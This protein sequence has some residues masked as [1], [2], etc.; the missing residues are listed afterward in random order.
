[1]PSVLFEGSYL[2]NAIEEQRLGS[3]EGRQILADA[4]ANA[5]QAYREGR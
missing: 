4:I 2:S 5:V 1:M 3:G